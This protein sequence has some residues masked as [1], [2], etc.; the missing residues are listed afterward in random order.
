MFLSLPFF[1]ISDHRLCRWSLMPARERDHN[2]QIKE[3]PMDVNLKLNANDL[4]REESFT[5]M[6]VGAIRVLTPVKVDGSTDDGR[7][8]I[9]IG[10]TQLMSPNGPLPVSCIVE[11]ASLK[12]AAEKFPDAVSQEVDRIVKLAQ[13]A[14][15]QEESRIVM[16]GR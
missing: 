13:Q 6:K 11:A 2:L 9:F 1:F 4:Y 15:Q 8:P 5:D 3:K 14:Q 10:Q 7:Q 16:P 12:D